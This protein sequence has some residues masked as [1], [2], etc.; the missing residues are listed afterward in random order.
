MTSKLLVIPGSESSPT[1]MAEQRALHQELSADHSSKELLPVVIKQEFPDDDHPCSSTTEGSSGWSSQ[2]CSGQILKQMLLAAPGL[3]QQGSAPGTTHSGLPGQS[4]HNSVASEDPGQADP[5]S[6]ETFF[7]L[8][9]GGIDDISKHLGKGV[10]T[11]VVGVMG[12]AE[13]TSTKVVSSGPALLPQREPGTQC[14]YGQL[15]S[16]HQES[17]SQGVM[18]IVPVVSRFGTSLLT[19]RTVGLPEPTLLFVTP[20]ATMEGMKKDSTGG[21]EN[22]QSHVEPVKRE[23]DDQSMETEADWRWYNSSQQEGGGWLE[24]EEDKEEEVEKKKVKKKRDKKEN[25]NAKLDSIRDDEDDES[26]EFTIGDVETD[27][28][29]DYEIDDYDDEE[30]EIDDFDEDEEEEEENQ[31][32][33]E[34][35]F[36]DWELDEIETDDDDEDRD[37]DVPPLPQGFWYKFSSGD[38]EDISA[39]HERLIVGESDQ[40]RAI[41]GVTAEDKPIVASASKQKIVFGVTAEE[42]IPAEKTFGPLEGC[43]VAEDEGCLSPSSWELCIKGSALLYIDGGSDWLSH[44]RCT[45][46]PSDQNIEALQRYGEIYFRTTKCIEPGSELRVFYSE[47]YSKRVGFNT[48]LK[49]LT[50]H[51]DLNAYSCPKCE[52]HYTN[53]KLMLRHIK[54]SHQ[55]KQSLTDLRPLITL[56][57]RRK[58]S[59]QKP[60]ERALLNEGKMYRVYRD[61]EMNLQ[62]DPKN[63]NDRTSTR[64]QPPKGNHERNTDGGPNPTP[65]KEFLCKICSKTFPTEGRLRA[66]KA[67]HDLTDDCEE[68]NTPE[69]SHEKNVEDHQ[70]AVFQCE[71]C[72]KIYRSQ[73]SLDSHKTLKHIKKNKYHSCNVCRVR[74]RYKKQLKD[75]KAEHYREKVRSQLQSLY[76]NRLIA[77]P[78]HPQKD[79]ANRVVEVD[80]GEGKRAGRLI[81]NKDGDSNSSRGQKTALQ[82]EKT[83]N[84]F[85]DSVRGEKEDGKLSKTGKSKNAVDVFEER[86]QRNSQLTDRAAEI[87]SDHARR[88]RPIAQERE[89]SVNEIVDSVMRNAHERKVDHL[90]RR[91]EEGWAE[92]SRKGGDDVVVVSDDSG[93]PQTLQMRKH[94][95]ELDKIHVR[96]QQRALQRSSAMKGI[97]ESVG[98]SKK[99]CTRDLSKAVDKSTSP[100][101]RVGP[102]N[103]DMLGKRP[104]YFENS[105]MK[106]KCRHCS[107]MYSSFSMMRVH[108]KEMH[109]GECRYKCQYCPKQFMERSRYESHLQKH[110]TDKIFKCTECPRSFASESALRNHQGEHTGL[111]PFKCPLCGKGF[112]RHEFVNAHIRR[113]H[114]VVELKHP[115]KQCNKRFA[116]SW[117]LKKHERRHAGYR[118]FKC[119]IC[120]NAFTAKHSLQCHMQAVH[121]KLKPYR[122]DICGKCS[123]LSHHH[124]AHLLQH[125]KKGEYKP[126]DV[127]HTTKDM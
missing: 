127:H 90:K 3:G 87:E 4:S 96:S 88:T 94:G 112:A 33:E 73:A 18:Q 52:I 57:T 120:G 21:A 72:N 39:P 62:V 66:H 34:D 16:H 25:N 70:K 8:S 99:Q 80:A 98:G 84:N 46:S 32:D 43:L 63:P 69:S 14:E 10:D 119:E 111:K 122:C 92:K 35:S 106:Y 97:G 22:S 101:D 85:I 126:G 55:T 50:F 76:R 81:G 86:S 49:D 71:L 118:P 23:G 82:R 47:E 104:N 27:D 64:N 40:S 53:P 67:F 123:S 113:L 105:E 42:K 109:G 78:S 79:K 41:V 28:E 91:R 31:I 38:G 65:T 2:G 58:A 115:C 59:N 37:M 108:E 51:T 110:N 77:D 44:I 13:N 15:Q 83:I 45:R 11:P 60:L 6:K 121:E 124:N 24:D 30:E 5:S 114:Q 7:I 89:L 20:D 117:D 100:E 56:E 26:M 75:H 102:S 12:S 1:I 68:T 74:F 48:K 19:N 29:D 9:S 116:T 17:H 125:K 103:N 61:Q 95:K 54:L 36:R 93:D 107:R